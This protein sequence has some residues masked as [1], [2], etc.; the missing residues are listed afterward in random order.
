MSFALFVEP[1]FFGADPKGTDQPM[2][3]AK[4]VSA[5]QNEAD[6]VQVCNLV[7]EFKQKLEGLNVP[8]CL[9]QL[10]R[11][12]KNFQYLYA[13]KGEAM[14]VS[15]NVSFHNF[16]DDE[17]KVTR[18]LM[19]LY[20]VN[21][22]RQD[23]LPK[24]RILDKIK[25]ADED[26][27][28][29]IV[30]LRPFQGQKKYLEGTSSLVFS[31][32]GK[33]VYMTRSGRSSEEVLEVLCSEENLNIPPCNRFIFDTAYPG[34]STP[35][36]HTNSVCF[37]GKDI[38][39]FA[40]PFIKFESDDAKEAFYDHLE[41][42]YKCVLY[43]NEAESKNFAANAVEVTSQAC[44]QAKLFISETAYKAL[45]MKNQQKLVKFYGKANIIQ[46]YGEVL[47]RRFGTSVASCV[48]I[49]RTV[50]EVA[51]LPCEKNILDLL[52]IMNE[53]H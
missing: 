36:T 13:A 42:S 44:G 3:K 19:V 30:D 35:I 1:V 38:A 17:G 34:T 15:Q 4:T 41:N 46:L 47:E 16:T 37:V 24:K 20:P 18:R 7:D 48:A 11:E 51:P 26:V 49:S 8:S 50:G 45:S 28:V 52:N 12:P 29:E 32:D 14:L 10:C 6:R 40:L 31:H 25:H 2:I 22:Y 33:Y 23:E 21:P 5:S 9:V 27:P 39:A 43:L 53:E